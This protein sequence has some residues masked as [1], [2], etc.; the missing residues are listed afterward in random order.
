MNLP[1]TELVNITINIIVIVNEH[2][3]RRCRHHHLNDTFVTG[4]R[5]NSSW[6]CRMLL[7]IL[8][9]PPPLHLGE[10]R[11]STLRLM[12]AIRIRLLT[13]LCQ[14][15]VFQ[16][17]IRLHSQATMVPSH[18]LSSRHSCMQT[19]PELALGL[20]PP[21]AG[22]SRLNKTHGSKARAAGKS[23]LWTPTTALRQPRQVTKVRPSLQTKVGFSH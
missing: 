10:H 12:L 3:H 11:K 15:S 4:T 1:S 17:Q 19:Q 2:R 6:V 16:L 18:H 20:K 5:V 13:W 21:A 14:G 23:G 9:H 8:V 7:A 22:H